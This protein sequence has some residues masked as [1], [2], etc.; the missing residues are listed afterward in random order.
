M[1]KAIILLSGGMDSATT[2][3]VAKSKERELY[4]I[5]FNYGQKHTEEIECAKKLSERYEVKEHKIIDISFLEDIV[6]NKSAL[7]GSSS[8]DLP[9][10]REES[11][12]VNIPTSYVPFRNTIFMSIAVAWAESMGVEE[13]YLGI[14]A[15]DYSGYPDCRPEYIMALET[16][17]ERGT[18]MGV[19][20]FKMTVYTPLLKKSKKD[21]V[22]MATDL[23]VP[24]E[25]TWSCYK[26]ENEPCGVCDSCILRAKGFKE[27]GVKDPLLSATESLSADK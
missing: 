9:E 22:L 10:N 6:K 20:G 21:I 14:N 7:V 8:V 23:K 15:L 4:T 16:L 17:I 5:S 19:E 13:I 2:L 24:L 26:G 3:G 1:E 25:L 18:K 12:M 27:A 11:E